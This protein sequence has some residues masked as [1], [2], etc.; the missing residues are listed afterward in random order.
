MIF[1]DKLQF[2]AFCMTVLMFVFGI[3]LGSPLV[4]NFRISLAFQGAFRSDID[5]CLQMLRNSK[6]ASLASEMLGS[7]SRG[8]P[9]FHHCFL[10]VAIKIAF[11]AANRVLQKLFSQSCELLHSWTPRNKSYI[12]PGNTYMGK[13]AA[14]VTICW[15]FYCVI[16]WF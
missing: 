12:E 3:A 16:K 5:I 1:G 15:I 9:S 13:S 11:F 7:G 10:F 14:G 4:A 6:N 2:S 8:P